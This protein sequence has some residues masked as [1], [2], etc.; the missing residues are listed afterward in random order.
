MIGK[1]PT[2][3]GTQLRFQCS[4]CGDTLCARCITRRKMG[5]VTVSICP[6]C[7]VSVDP[8]DPGE[9]P[10]FAIAWDSLLEPFRRVDSF[11]RLGFAAAFCTLLT[12]L[13]QHSNL[14]WLKYGVYGLIGFFYASYLAAT[15]KSAIDGMSEIPNPIRL[16]SIVDDLVSPALYLVGALVLSLMPLALIILISDIVSDSPQLILTTWQ[17]E[18]SNA[19]ST[20]LFIVIAYAAF[21]API[22]I[23][24]AIYTKHLFNA[25]NPFLLLQLV[26]KA[27]FGYFSSLLIMYLSLFGIFG[28]GI[29]LYR[30]LMLELNPL[31][32]G[33]FLVWWFAFYGGYVFSAVDGGMLFTYSKKLKIR[34]RSHLS[35]SSYP[36]GL[37]TYPPP[38]GQ[39]LP[40]RTKAK[41]RRNSN[42]GK[43]RA[44]RAAKVIPISYPPQGPSRSRSS[45]PPERTA[46]LERTSSANPAPSSTPTRSSAP[47]KAPPYDLIS[48][49]PAK[50]PSR[51]PAR[52]NLKSTPAPENIT[53]T[54]VEEL[55]K[56]Y[57][58]KLREKPNF[59]LAPEQQW[60]VASHFERQ[61][62]WNAAID[63]YVNL[64]TQPLKHPR[65]ADGLLRASFLTYSKLKDEKKTT[66]L[67]I[68]L[69]DRYPAHPSAEKGIKVLSAI[70]RHS[71]P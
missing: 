64:G 41:P 62:Q 55:S 47:P 29:L 58:E 52:K 34:V 53:R 23:P 24:V 33:F 43:S 8:L 4:N 9:V 14:A 60:A 49:P 27:P 38:Y 21:F 25:T 22:A 65:G 68:S 12:V 2:H 11:L 37:T 5:T 19:G 1:C 20:L 15:V 66:D 59:T 50:K 70:S 18:P 26:A 30:T 57:R 51:P 35:R 71:S 16:S 36:D 10:L 39:S 63:A 7:S 32:T 6:E 61:G 13:A 67:L 31:Y 3:P 48:V 56:I 45:I 54:S 69:I 28:I 17:A 44:T 42:S 40:I 46:P